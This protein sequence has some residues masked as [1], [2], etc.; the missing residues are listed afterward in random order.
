MAEQQHRPHAPCVHCGNTQTSQ[1]RGPNKDLC[2]NKACKDIA[3][4]AFAQLKESEK[5]RRITELEAKVREQATTIALLRAQLEECARPPAATATVSSTTTEPAIQAQQRAPKRAVLTDCTNRQQ[6][7]PAPK[8]AKKPPDQPPP[9]PQLPR[10]WTASSADGHATWE[11]EHF[12]LELL[13]APSYQA[14]DGSGYTVQ[15]QL[16]EQLVSTYVDA[17]GDAMPLS[18]LRADFEHCF[19]LREGRVLGSA[20]LTRAFD[21]GLAKAVVLLAQKEAKHIL[22][23]SMTDESQSDAECVLA[24]FQHATLQLKAG[25]TL[26]DAR[27][28]LREHGR[29]LSEESVRAIVQAHEEGG[30]L[31]SSID[32]AHFAATACCPRDFVED[33]II[34]FDV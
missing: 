6:A 4:K 15:P 33:F 32:D 29:S 19:A 2:S 31:Y 13:E 8:R 18:E 3:A 10:G 24:F 14:A 9:E 7:A 26:S 30:D 12:G 1:W 21:A 16:L 28:T 5:D 17:K 34:H 23:E 27:A 11:Y 22:Q 25:A 20:R